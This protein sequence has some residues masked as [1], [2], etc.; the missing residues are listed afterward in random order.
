MVFNF[1][2]IINII[3]LT[4]YSSQNVS[5]FNVLKFNNYK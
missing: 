4:E 2:M 1:I 3:S 5:D